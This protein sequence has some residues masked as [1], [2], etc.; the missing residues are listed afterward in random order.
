MAQP[1]KYQREHDFTLDEPSDVSTSSLNREF[2]DIAV[3]TDGLRENL[4]K[5]QNDDSSLRAGIVTPE[6]LSKEV[7]ENINKVV[8]EAN[9]VASD[10]AHKAVVAANSAEDSANSAQANADTCGRLVESAKANVEAVNSRAADVARMVE[11]T[12]P[13]ID[14]I[15][16]VK[17]V[18]EHISE[19][20]D[21]S[22]SI[23]D[24]RKVASDLEGE[25]QESGDEDYG[26]VADDVVPGVVTTGGSI[27]TV[28]QDI[29]SVKSVA[30]NIDSIN[31]AAGAVDAVLAAKD[32]VVAASDRA[33]GS[34]QLSHDWAVKTDGLVADEDHSSKW[35]AEKAKEAANSA[36]EAADSATFQM[37]EQMVAFYNAYYGADLDYR[38]YLDEPKSELLADFYGF[39]EGYEGVTDV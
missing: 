27:Y 18:C 37:V 26:S 36:I 20:S 33:A 8:K 25:V 15:D 2:D 29:E 7:V 38:D 16:Q 31:K 3:T 10:A 1:Q 17:T 30:A 5:I 4:A 24:V 23:D 39:C 35:Y 9:A 11:V 12:R 28:A 14:G 22:S 21:V 19:V 6:S 13:V 34:E 32:V